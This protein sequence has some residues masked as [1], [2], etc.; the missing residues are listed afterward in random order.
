MKVHL[1]LGAGAFNE[2]IE[3]YPLTKAYLDKTEDPNFFDFQCAVNHR[4][5]GLS[6]FI[7]GFYHQ[8]VEVL[9]PESL[10][11]HLRGELNRMQF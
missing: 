1:R 2:L 7:L 3:R 11:E 6:N 10:K 9:A 8:H 5:D 4:F